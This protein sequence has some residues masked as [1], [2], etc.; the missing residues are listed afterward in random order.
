MHTS[1]NDRFKPYVTWIFWSSVKL[2]VLAEPS[3]FTNLASN[4]LL[5][6]LNQSWYGTVNIDIFD[7]VVSAACPL[8][9]SLKTKESYSR[10]WD[11]GPRIN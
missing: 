6:L 2:T 9:F 10:A 7:N 8:F 4:N 11:D 5:G 1:I 3:K